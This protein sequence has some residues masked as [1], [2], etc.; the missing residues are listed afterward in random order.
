MDWF[1][2]SE[3]FHTFAN[4]QQLTNPLKAN[5]MESVFGKR[6]ANARKIKCLS[7]R[8]LCEKLGGIVSSNAIA[9]YEAGK[10][11]PSSTT[12]IALSK[13]LGMEIDYFFR[14]FTFQIDADKFEFRK[15]SSLGKK[16]ENALK[17]TIIAQIEKYLEVES[18]THDDKHFD[19]DFRNETVSTSNDARALANRLREKLDLGTDCIPNPI[20]VLESRGVK[21]IEV[22]ANNK[23]D[24]SCVC[25]NQIPV[26]VL[27]KHT[28]SERKRLTLFHELAHL[29]LSFAEHADKERLC[30]IFANEVLLPSA[31]LKQMIGERRKNISLVELKDIQRL[32]GISVEAIMAKAR[33]LSII[34]ESQYRSFCIS[35]NKSDALKEKIRETVYPQEHT[36]RYERI[37]YKAL[38]DE[39]I[40]ASKA[41]NLLNEPVDVV[42]AH[43]NVA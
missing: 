18:I 10:M 24:G 11:L 16:Q 17:E 26:I 31:V 36:T 43:I 1:T 23:F 34:N 8:E 40:S 5:I 21:V 37:V 30:N 27:N 6:L 4:H 2:D 32:Y 41:A 33:Q 35:L 42:L 15:K 7:Q 38:S 9:K 13:A 29:I 14:P 28:C 39:L 3:Y 25:E 12:L 22:E 19:I 20:E